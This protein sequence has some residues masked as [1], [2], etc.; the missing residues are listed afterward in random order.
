MNRLRSIIALLYNTLEVLYCF[1]SVVCEKEKTNLRTLG[2][3]KKTK[4]IQLKL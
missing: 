3:K 4:M 1:K 2:N